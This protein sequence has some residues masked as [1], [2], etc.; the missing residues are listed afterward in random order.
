M[1]VLLSTVT[2]LVTRWCWWARATAR[3]N[4]RYLALSRRER[5]EP[6][7]RTTSVGA[8]GFTTATGAS[9]RW[10]LA[11]R[12]TSS[13]RVCRPQSLQRLGPALGHVDGPGLVASLSTANTNSRLASSS[14]SSAAVVVM[15][16]AT[17]PVTS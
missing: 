8:C 13:A 17:G 16:R 1:T 10:A 11:C 14:S 15:S 5:V 4:P 6:G 7:R 2:C 9:R 12:A 3:I